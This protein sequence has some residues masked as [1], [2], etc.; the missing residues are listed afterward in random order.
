MRVEWDNKYAVTDNF[1]SEVQF[2]PVQCRL[3]VES[4]EFSS[5]ELTKQTNRN[6]KHKQI[7][8]WSKVIVNSTGVVNI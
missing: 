5:T 6:T 7:T 8:D 3:I 1:R 2:S 4:T